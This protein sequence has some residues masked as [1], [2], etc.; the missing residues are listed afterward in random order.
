MS[1]GAL[2]VWLLVGLLVVAQAAGVG[3]MGDTDT[4]G[5]TEPAFFVPLLCAAVAAAAAVFWQR[6]ERLLWA[7]LAV[8]LAVGAVAESAFHLSQQQGTGVATS[9]A[10]AY[11]LFCAAA[12]AAVLAASGEFHFRRAITQ[13]LGVCS[14]G[15]ATAWTWFFLVPAGSS[16]DS[17][18]SALDL[19][20][21]LAVLAAFCNH[22]WPVAP[23][24]AM[25]AG[26]LGLI[27][28]ADSMQSQGVLTET[29]GLDF[30]DALPFAGAALIS[31]VACWGLRPDAKRR[32][33]GRLVVLLSLVAVV[34]AVAA[35]I[36]DHYARI[37]SGTVLLAS[38]TLLAAGIRLTVAQRGWRDARARVREVEAE[39]VE[40]TT[41]DAA[42]TVGPDGTIAA[43]NERAYAIFRRNDFE[44]VGK[45]VGNLLD[46]GPGGRSFGELLEGIEPH[47]LPAP[48]ELNAYDTHGVAFPVEVTIGPSPGRAS[49][50]TLVVRDITER[51]RRE[52]ENRRL[53][54]IIR[55]SDDAVL[56]KDL[57]GTITGWNQGAERIYGYG[58]EE[59]IGKQV[60]ELLIPATRRAEAKRILKEVAA[61][62]VVSFET[63]RLTKN[64]TLIDITLRAFPIRGLSGEVTAVCTVA[65][66]VSERR[67]RERAEQ[68]DAEALAWRKRLRESLGSGGLLFHGQP[69]LDLRSG[70]VHHY[71][72][73]VR[74][75]I[76]GDLVMPGAFLPY[77]E[78]TELIRDLDLW[79]VEEGMRLSSRVPV[80]INLSAR[81]LG[82]RGLLSA[83]ERRL[84]GEGSPPENL[85]FEI[86]ET[87]AAENMQGARELVSELTKM[88]CGVA[89]DDFGT[90]YGSFTYLR[91]LPVTQL[92]IDTEFIRGIGA[93]PADRR[94]VESMIDVARNFEMT[95]VAEGVED[96]RTL[97]LLREMGVD[98][99]QGYY[100]G[101]PQPLASA[102][103][104]GSDG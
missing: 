82:S 47:S 102:N 25:L 54:A 22:G 68:Q 66:D 49:T 21:A 72:L 23:R 28:V 45:P 11:G 95:T 4:V 96:E 20:L 39:A 43:C 55:S 67:R 83:I 37:S 104:N 36:Y 70:Q 33:S 93:D 73:L 32:P 17:L 46:G 101:R 44:I 87:A 88:G 94:V 63:Q 3:L 26:G 62:E 85:T 56:T 40:A 58:A 38:L 19:L 10:V 64:G 75:R 5:G 6:E 35:L 52:E 81:S 29:F 71:E 9:A 90:G 79:A 69:I 7:V 2:L 92:K 86:T 13:G 80:A 77:A 1:R 76:D 8:G 84:S 42:I 27:A 100:V 103:G 89:L 34:V 59:A 50:R 53:A 91:H 98:L 41:L 61:G 65:H 57:S 51:K 78:E 18:H 74:M 97:D 15:L 31:I 60:T 12:G 16:S 30:A 24:F 14:F 99:A 48:L